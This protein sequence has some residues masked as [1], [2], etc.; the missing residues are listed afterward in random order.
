MPRAAN[1]RALPTRTCFDCENAVYPH[2]STFCWTFQESI[3]DEVAAASD[4]PAYEQL[5]EDD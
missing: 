3:L 5:P 4:C 1:E 2:G